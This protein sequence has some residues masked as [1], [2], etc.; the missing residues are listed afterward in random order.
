MFQ[1]ALNRWW[2]ALMHF[3]GPPTDPAKDLLIQYHVK[4]DG[5]EA[6]R[7]RFLDRYVPRIWSL[8]YSLPDPTLRRL[9]ERMAA[10]STGSPT[11]KSSSR[12]LPTTGPRARSGWRCGA[13]SGAATR[14]WSSS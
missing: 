3:F 2:E 8:G 6:L 1:G 9:P 10:G 12:S 13:P 11:G 7:Q 5:N 14:P 4:T